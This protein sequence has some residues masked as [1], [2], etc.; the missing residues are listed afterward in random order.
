[1]ALRKELALAA[2][3]AL[4]LLVSS[5]AEDSSVDQV[6][7]DNPAL[8]SLRSELRSK[9]KDI[10]GLKSELKQAK[11]AQSN[12]D[13][14]AA[15]LK[16]AEEKAETYGKHIKATADKATAL[17]KA[18]AE[19]K[20]KASE[21]LAAKE[22]LAEKEKAL[23]EAQAALKA[24]QESINALDAEKA[25]ALKEVEKLSSELTNLQ[26][27]NKNFEKL[28]KELHAATKTLQDR[29]DKSES[30]LKTLE[31]SLKAA[32]KSAATSQ[33]AL[34]AGADSVRPL[35]SNAWEHASKV[36]V[37]ARSKSVELWKA[38]QVKVQALLKD[39]KPLTRK[40]LVK[41]QGSLSKLQ[42]A[43]KK[44]AIPQLQKALAST[45]AATHK[46]L[47]HPQV[48]QARRRVHK[49]I[50]DLKGEIKRYMKKHALTSKYAKEP[51]LTYALYT[52]SA[53][54]LTL[55]LLPFWAVTALLRGK[56]SRTT[57]RPPRRPSAS[58]STTSNVQGVK[59]AKTKNAG[60]GKGRRITMGGDSIRVP[61]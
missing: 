52:A 43:V 3:L 21:A 12:V 10:A 9:D 29:A 30:T 49:A 59:N 1:M 31:A 25:A 60:A 44:H 36:H 42:L 61:E 48:L 4:A 47:S 38:L 46:L 28:Q 58:S 45:K 56:K 26:K 7:D 54:S 39:A 53:L 17:E 23:S 20:K 2:L 6:A 18:A 15:K 34:Q 51:F 19:S 32:E 37:T 8:K 35:A 57:R 41:L 50:Q 33:K 16:A 5:A 55:C 40:Y 22:A 11:A 13:K 27:V 14:I 24:S